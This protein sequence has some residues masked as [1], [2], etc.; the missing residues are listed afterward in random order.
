MLRMIAKRN[1]LEKRAGILTGERVIAEREML[2]LQEK[3][4]RFEERR[5]QQQFLQKQ[6]DL[7]RLISEH[8]L[9]AEEILGGMELGLGASAEGILDA[10]TR[11]M[12][13]VITQADAQ[14]QALTPAM[15]QGGNTIALP[16]NA[17]GGGNTIYNQ[18]TR[19]NN[20]TVN[21]LLQPNELAFEFSAMETAG[22]VAA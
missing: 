14:L 5:Q 11:A 1:A 10:M 17:M 7:V 2:R 16:G 19:Q 3:T 6:L 13:M 20:L 9:N 4:A 8:G 21:S 22:A 18:M 12:G 15:L